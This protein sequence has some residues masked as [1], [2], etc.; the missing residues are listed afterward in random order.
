MA[1]LVEEF[2][3]SSA[4]KLFIKII[5]TRL[6]VFTC[7]MRAFRCFSYTDI[8]IIIVFLGELLYGKQ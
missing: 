2:L 6:L 3:F 7:N 4:H 8:L 1:L 5:Y